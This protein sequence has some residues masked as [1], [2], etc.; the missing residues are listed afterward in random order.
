MEFEDG[1]SIQVKGRKG[2]RDHREHQKIEAFN[3]RFSDFFAGMRYRRSLAE[4]DASQR[5]L[6]GEVKELRR[7]VKG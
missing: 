3:R 4:L 5:G 1:I 6:E 7:L 2:E